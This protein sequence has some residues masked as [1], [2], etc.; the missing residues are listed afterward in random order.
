MKI[1]LRIPDRYDD[2]IRAS[3][4]ADR[5]SINSWLIEA[6][7][8]YLEAPPIGRDSASEQTGKVDPTLAKIRV[9]SAQV[10]DHPLPVT[11]D[12]AQ[13]VARGIRSSDFA[14]KVAD[15][16]LFHGQLSAAILE[17]TRQDSAPVN[18]AP[19]IAQPER[20]ARCPD[21]RCIGGILMNRSCLSLG[22]SCH[23]KQKKS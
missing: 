22:C 16:E 13:V 1:M 14:Q 17:V 8:S 21:C 18:S 23:K 7:I 4:G 20:P 19:V 12:S 5:R 3:A 11:E 2:Q 9:D 15:A 10:K 6:V